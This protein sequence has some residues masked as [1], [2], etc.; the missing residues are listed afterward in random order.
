MNIKIIKKAVASDQPEKP[1]LA[2]VKPTTDLPIDEP[3]G[4]GNSL[5]VIETAT[6]LLEMGIYCIPVVYKSKAPAIPE[7]PKLKIAYFGRW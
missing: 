1:P 4:N 6:K 2:L 7:W 3:Q 5:S